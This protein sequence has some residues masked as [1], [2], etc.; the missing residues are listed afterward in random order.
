V[1]PDGALSVA[2]AQG[3]GS[4]SQFVM[5][6]AT[7][8]MNALKAYADPDRARHSRK[9][10]KTG[11]GEYGAGDRFLG[12]RVPD[13]RKVARQFRSLSLSE[14]AELINSDWHEIRFLAV[15]VLVEQF[16][17]ANPQRQAQLYKTYMQHRNG[18]NNWD[19][20]DTSAPI[21]VGEHF[22]NR[23]RKEL[24]RLAQSGNLW[25]RRIA[26]LACFR[27]IRD[28]DFQDALAIA[29]LLLFDTQDLIHKAVGWMLREIGN[30]DRVVAERFLRQHCHDMPRTMLRYAIEKFP[31]SQRQAYLRECGAARTETSGQEKKQRE[32]ANT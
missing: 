3:L 12:V 11:E 6:I 14:Y 31:A 9:Y 29:E 1:L 19:L 15:V 7:L 4:G 13:T 10:F 25:D 26:V 27:F 2:T 32:P 30:R 16:R 21:V 23:S 28:Q 5:K 22:L 8:V 24:Y 20:V 18:I 17:Q